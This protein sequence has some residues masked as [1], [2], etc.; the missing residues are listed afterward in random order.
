MDL[1]SHN[2][3]DTLGKIENNASFDAPTLAEVWRSSPYFHDGRYATLFELFK[4]GLHG[5]SVPSQSGEIDD[6]LA[7]V[8][9]LPYDPNLASQSDHALKRKIFAAKLLPWHKIQ[10]DFFLEKHQQVG[11]SVVDLQGKQLM[12]LFKNTFPKGSHSMIFDLTKIKYSGLIFIVLSNGKNYHIQKIN[13][14]HS[15]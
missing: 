13:W 2:I 10:L 9:S 8:K 7:F 3:I 11:A 5:M 4:E 15:Y 14:M 1:Q 12:G 6:L